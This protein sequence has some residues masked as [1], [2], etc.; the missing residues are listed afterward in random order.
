MDQAKIL[1]IIA[2]TLPSLITAGIAYYCFKLYF[3][4]E[5]NKIKYQLFKQNNKQAFPLKLQAYER[6]ILYLER[7]HLA[8][9]LVKTTPVSTNKDDY[10][11]VIIHQIESEFEHNLTQQL[12]LSSDSWNSIIN[13]KNATI[14]IIRNTTKKPEVN[15]ADQLREHLLSD[16]LKQKSP[17]IIAIEIL[18][19][20]LKK[21]IG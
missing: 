5:Q 7:I 4:N 16:L 11:N 12:Y 20:E 8:K 1:E 18:K 2:Y 19:T 14:Q 3:K 10:Q 6:M 9:L 13:C 15:S 21:S 17:N